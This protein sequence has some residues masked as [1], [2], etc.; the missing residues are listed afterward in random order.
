MGSRE[1]TGGA[2][3]AP[4]AMEA[5]VSV[6]D[7]S[8]VYGSGQNAVRALRHVNLAVPPHNLVAIT[9]RSGSGKTTLLNLM[10]GL[11]T[12]TEGRIVLE[13]RDITG[14]SEQERTR[15]RRHKVGFIFQSFALLPALSALENVALALHIA[16]VAA[17]ERDRRA[18]EALELVGLGER[19]DHRPY[20]LSGGEQERVAVARALV[21]RPAVILA[22]EPTG[23]LDTA[24]GHDIVALLKHLV[25]TED[26][27]LVVA[28]H[29]PAV[30]EAADVVYRI[31]DG[32]LQ[33][34][35]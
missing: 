33:R 24:T 25:S 2:V 5:I 4:V 12:P 21:N 17:K 16:G 14:L 8:H 27:T 30:T 1:P 26:L 23:E 31:A 29:D 18:R 10:G 35:E 20:E 11:D 22:D 6:Q 34:A 3:A 32:V 15:L 7:V 19:L 9:G 28:T 13:G